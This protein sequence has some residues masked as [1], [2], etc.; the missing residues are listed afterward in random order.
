MFRNIPKITKNLLII[1]VIIWVASWIMHKTGN[2]LLMDWFAL[3][4]PTGSED[5]HF[6]IWQLFTYMFLHDDTSI[7]HIFFN[8]W[9]LL[10]FGCTLERTWGSAKYLLF[11]VVCGVGAALCELGVNWIQFAGDMAHYEP[12]SVRMAYDMFTTVGA[13]GAIYGLLLGFGMLYPDTQF[14]LIF[15]PIPL[16]AKWMVIIFGAMEIVLS[17]VGTGNVAHVAHLGGM[18]FGL[19]LILVWKKNMKLYDNSDY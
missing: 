7:M 13:S 1:N 4:F 16:K 12:N 2:P 6:H 11:Y 3:H 19:V 15:P 8:M 17:I 9:S 5:S 14:M 10:L 18:L